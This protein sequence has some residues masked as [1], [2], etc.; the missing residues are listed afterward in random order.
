MEEAAY[1]RIRA[2][3]DRLKLVPGRG[4]VGENL[5][6]DGI[7]PGDDGHEVLANAIGAA[8]MEVLI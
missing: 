8:V 3:D 2:G 7:H 5:L 1:A 4:L 6:V